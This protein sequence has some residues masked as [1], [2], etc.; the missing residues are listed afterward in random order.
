MKHCYCYFIKRFLKS[1]A[2]STKCM[3]F[4]HYLNIH[5]FVTFGPFEKKVVILRDTSSAKAG[6]RVVGREA[7]Q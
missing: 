2:P 1:F 3:P 7:F 6:D 4:F 5:Y